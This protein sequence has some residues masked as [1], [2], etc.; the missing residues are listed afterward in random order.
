MAMT[1]KMVNTAEVHRERQSLPCTQWHFYGNLSR[2]KF[3]SKSFSGTNFMIFKI[4]SAKK[5][6]FLTQNKAK[7]CKNL[8]IALLV[9]KKNA[10]FWQKSQKIVIIT[11]VPGREVFFCHKKIFASVSS[12]SE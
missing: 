4:F 9:F 12:H 1:G 11:S 3:R 5:I 7:L 6:A 8:I 2:N 10:N